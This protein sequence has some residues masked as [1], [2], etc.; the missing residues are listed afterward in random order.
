MRTSYK[1]TFAK[2]EVFSAELLARQLPCL[3][4]LGRLDGWAVTAGEVERLRADLRRE[5]YDLLLWHSLPMHLE[6]D[7]DQ[8][9]FDQ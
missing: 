7:F 3:R 5:N 4:L 6:M 9:L 8:E 1:R 2:F